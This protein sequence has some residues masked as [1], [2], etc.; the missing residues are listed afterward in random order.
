M[1]E[2]GDVEGRKKKRRKKRERNWFLRL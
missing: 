1:Q 2:E